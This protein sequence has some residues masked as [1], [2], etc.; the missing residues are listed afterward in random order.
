[1]TWINGYPKDNEKG[2]EIDGRVG[3]SKMVVKSMTYTI[4]NK[5]KKVLFCILAKV[6]TIFT[7][8][9]E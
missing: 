2:N 9:I 5:E 4:F 6:D 1:M 3:I 8:K 7:L